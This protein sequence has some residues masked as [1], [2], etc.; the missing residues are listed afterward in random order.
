MFVSDTKTCTEC[1]HTK[2]SAQRT[3]C[4]ACGVESEPG[5]QFPFT[6]HHGD[7]ECCGDEWRHACSPACLH[8]VIVDLIGDTG[9]EHW[10][11]GLTV[12]VEGFAGV[13]WLA[14][15]IAPKEGACPST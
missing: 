4:D 5:S 6:V 15:S 13:H 3:R 11:S 8:A 7:P 12:E 10:L 1:G 9:V 14:Q 2:H